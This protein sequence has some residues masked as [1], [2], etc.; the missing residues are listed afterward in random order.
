MFLIAFRMEGVLAKITL[1]VKLVLCPAHSSEVGNEFEDGNKF[2]R[3]LRRNVSV[4]EDR[5]KL[6]PLV[7]M[8]KGTKKRRDIQVRHDDGDGATL[9]Y[10]V[11]LLDGC[12]V[13][14]RNSDIPR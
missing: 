5:S 12:T 3:A 1:L 7:A 6:D 11:G 8:L 14:P 9:P 4:I 13:C 10:S 2:L